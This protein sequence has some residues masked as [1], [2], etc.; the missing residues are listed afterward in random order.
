MAELED[1]FHITTL[2]AVNIFSCSLLNFLTGSLRWGRGGGELRVQGKSIYEQSI[3]NQKQNHPLPCQQQN[4]T[5]TGSF[6]LHT[7]VSK[8]VV[9]QKRKSVRNNG[10]WYYGY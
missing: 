6:H 7:A 10:K 9:L 2:W 4:T 5:K 1:K 8:K 3:F